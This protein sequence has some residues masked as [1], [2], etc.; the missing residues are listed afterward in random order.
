MP[1]MAKLGYPSLFCNSLVVADDGEI[2]FKTQTVTMI[3]DDENHLI[4]YDKNGTWGSE[5][6]WVDVVNARFDLGAFFNR[7]KV[8]GYMTLTKTIEGDVTEEDLKKYMEKA[9]A[10]YKY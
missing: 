9:K 4:Q 3:G 6:D 10:I 1:L 5:T 7:V 8:P 2:R